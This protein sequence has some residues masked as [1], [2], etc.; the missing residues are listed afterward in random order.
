MAEQYYT[1]TK[2]MVLNIALGLGTFIQVLDSSIANVAIPY[3]AGNLSVSADDGTWVITSFA[4][5][6]A[7]V[8]P[9]TGWLSDYFG[10]VRLFVYSLILFSI[11]SF[12][13]G[14]STSLT[15]L[16]FFRVLQGAVAGA[17]IPLSQS[18][19][20]SNSPPEKRGS[21]LGF[22]AMVVIVAPVLGPIVGGYLTYEYSWP[23]IFYIN[24]PIGILSAFVTWVM[25][26]DRDTP[27]VR[28]PIDWTGLILLSLGVAS[29]QILLDKGRDLDWYDSNVIVTLGVIA[30]ISLAYFIVW[31]ANAK[32]PIV[33]FS[34]FN[35]RN[36]VLGTMIMTLGYTMYFGATVII[37]LWLQTQQGYT[38][39][40][41]GYAVAPVGIIPV[42]FSVQV[43]KNL[44]RF[45]LRH[46]TALSFFLFSV[47]FFY[48][49]NFTT[50]VDLYTVMFTRFIQG[51]GV[52]IFFVPLVQLSL[53]NIPDEKYASASGVFNFIRTLVGSGFGTSITIYI[54][55]RFETWHY[56]RLGDWIKMSKPVVNQTYHYLG[57]QNDAFTPEVIRRVINQGVEQQAFML[58]TNDLSWL[59]AWAFLVMVPIP[60]LCKPI[61]KREGAAAAAH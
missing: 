19:L 20:V 16:V 27:I 34:F 13:C 46:V 31:N 45:D 42:L 48:Q 11:M 59:C 24:V 3:I 17:L 10:S 38:A 21:A 28:N 52:L 41:A 1:G 61:R 5:S 12:L 6:N 51:F 9:L 35:Y 14:F 2:R 25:L 36:F 58:S 23:W 44:H 53:G 37:P 22:W 54:W 55:Y 56:N 57:Y 32:Y 43:G 29:L 26:K 15:M 50:D 33:D 49:A 4:A 39:E 8:L 60:F 18:L 40:W 7:I 30:V 47:S